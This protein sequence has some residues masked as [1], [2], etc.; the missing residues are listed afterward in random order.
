VERY[1]V[2][3]RRV[4]TTQT[5]QP[6]EGSNATRVSYLDSSGVNTP[7]VELAYLHPKNRCAPDPIIKKPWE[8]LTSGV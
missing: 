3:I 5:V 7:Y 6:T 2:G 8:L 4:P 1:V